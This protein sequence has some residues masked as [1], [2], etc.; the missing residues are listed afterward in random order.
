[1]SH[2]A[3]GG[4]R[5]NLFP[6]RGFGGR[7]GHEWHPEATQFGVIGLSLYGI[8]ARQPQSPAAPAIASSSHHPHRQPAR[9]KKEADQIAVP[10]K[11]HSTNG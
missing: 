1:M 7:Y 11:M 10:G 9:L 2:T 8:Q 5:E 4:N 6:A 3:I